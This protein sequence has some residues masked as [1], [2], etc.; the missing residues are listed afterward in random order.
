MRFTQAI[1]STPLT[2]PAHASLFTGLAPPEHGVEVNG[3]TVL[4]GTCLP[5]PALFGPGLCDRGVRRLAVLDRQFGLARGFEHYDDQVPDEITP[6]G[7][8]GERPP[9]R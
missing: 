9:A 1:A 4:A 6:D 5:S 8:L 7:H 2:L 3:T